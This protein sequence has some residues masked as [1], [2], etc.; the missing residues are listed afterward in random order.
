MLGSA[1]ST[2]PS[3]WQAGVARVV[4]T[5]QEPLWMAG[6]DRGPSQ[7]TAQELTAKA[8]VMQD[9]EG[10]RLVLVT[11]DLLGL[12]AV[13]AGRVANDI[14][15]RRMLTRDQIMLTASHTHCGPRLA[16]GYPPTIMPPDEGVKVQNYTDWLR[17]RLVSVV[18]MAFADLQPAV[19]GWGRGSATFAGNRR[20][21]TAEGYVNG[22]NP[23]GPTDNDVPVLSVMSPQGAL[24]A[25]VFG[26][27]C[28][29]NG[30][31]SLQWHGDYAG[32]AQLNLEAA[33]PGATALFFTGCAGDINQFG[34]TASGVENNAQQLTAAIEQALA[35]GMTPITGSAQSVFQRV[36]IPITGETA[37]DGRSLYPYPVQLWRLGDDL[38]WVSLGGEAVVDY[39]LRIKN[40]LGRET[41]VT[42][43]AN[44]T[45]GYV[46]SARV[47]AEGGYESYLGWAFVNARWG[48]Q[49]EE[50]IIGTVHEL[51]GTA[52][53]PP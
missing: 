12:D 45:M 20:L 1:P 39:S 19:L 43:Y 18:D 3:A 52:P 10:R 42:A 2:D 23:D 11:T 49:A 28:H 37:P 29:N 15:Q 48:T 6:Y 44:D 30:W 50:L 17:D 35:G 16:T 51:A 36:D 27:A 8:L 21:P 5:P 34:P 13:L 53:G 41:W 38:T 31:Y 32:H 40:E 7:G 4:I 26:Y 47:L 46:A 22:Y 9:P 14:I 24:R 25:I 33:H